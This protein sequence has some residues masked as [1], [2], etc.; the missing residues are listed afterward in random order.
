MI[1]LLLVAGCVTN[2][3]AAVQKTDGLPATA[4]LSGA[5]SPFLQKNLSQP[6]LL[7]NGSYSI[8]ASIDHIETV[9]SKPGSHRLDIYVNVENIGTKS[10]LPIWYSRITDSR[11]VAH[12][13]VGI[14]HGGAGVEGPLLDPGSSVTARDYITFESDAD[15][16]ALA[17]G[18]TLDI[19]FLGYRSDLTPAVTFR[20]AWILEPGNI[21]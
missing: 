8:S 15:F 21:R 16:S 5:G 14:S 2:G 9:S 7:T 3:P 6:A 18:G 13:G 4:G 17:Q 12:G 19:V 1:C 10:V 20:S 11:G